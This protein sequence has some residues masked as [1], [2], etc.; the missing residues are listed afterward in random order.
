MQ[1]HSSPARRSGFSLVELLLS[2]TVL[3]AI[4]L[5]FVGLLDQT[6]KTWEFSRT[7]ISQFREARLAFDIISKNVSQATLN[8]YFEQIDKNGKRASDFP[9]PKDFIPK[10]FQ[11]QSELHFKT[12][13]A[14]DLR[15]NGVITTGPGH[16]LFF[17][18]PLG[19]TADQRY[20][21]LTNLLNGR[22]Y[23]IALMPDDA[24][25]PKF[26]TQVGVAPKV[27]YRLMEF[28]PPTERNQVYAAANEADSAGGNAQT[29]T[30][31]M[32]WITVPLSAGD[33]ATTIRPLAE[34]I[35]AFIVSPRE[36]IA[37]TSNITAMKDRT[38]LVEADQDA[39]AR[40]APQYEYDS[41]RPSNPDAWSSHT[42]PPLIQIT[43]VAIDEVSAMRLEE[44]YG[45]RFM[46]H[47]V[48]GQWMESADAYRRDLDILTQKFEQ[49][50]QSPGG[51][52]ISFK[53]FTTTV[54]INGAKWSVP[55]GSTGS[56]N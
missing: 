6:Q 25:R 2:M 14:A 31:R 29:V 38:S 21:P 1:P 27:R 44:R 3:T 55:P 53:V 40:V 18:A 42:L 54:R 5:M 45:T 39:T 23:F 22:G 52:K 30:E 10:E 47:F 37:D 11:I 36:A 17:Q 28:L 56:N 4:L 19:S 13:R 33:S 8:A 20:T 24:F 32:K 26:L 16:A 7:Q 12:M 43:M 50:S 9:D 48:S 46:D 49:E 41:S 51:V 34:N 15:V 35:V